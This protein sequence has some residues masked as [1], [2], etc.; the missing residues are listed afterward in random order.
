MACPDGSRFNASQFDAAMQNLSLWDAGYCAYAVP[1][2][3]AVVGTLFYGAVS[4]GIFIRT[5]SLAI[6]SILF[7][8]LGATLIG[9]MLA[10]ISPLVGLIVL[11]N[12]PLLATALVWNLDR[13]S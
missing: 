7:L 12:A 2:G 4:L 5:G 10:V 3:E 11:V 1:M 6:P 13:F 8:I 9:Q